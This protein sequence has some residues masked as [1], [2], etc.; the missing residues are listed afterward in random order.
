[1]SSSPCRCLLVSDF[2]VANLAGYLRS[3]PDSPAVETLEAPFGQVMPTL[4]DP[5]AEVWRQAYDAVV[6]WTQAEGVLDSFRR[7]LKYDPP[8]TDEL[9]GELDRYAEA[10]L[11]L[12]DRVACV[13]VP[14]W[15]APP[16]Q[17]G[18]GILDFREGGVSHTLAKL[19]ARLVD[20]LDGRGNIFVLNTQQWIGATGIA[21][22]SPKLWYM[23]KI[24]FGAEVFKQAALDVKAA[25]RAVRG[26]ARKLL[27]LDLDDT[28]WGGVVGEVGWQGLR[29]GGHDPLGEAFVD[30]QRALKAL[31]RRGTVLAIASKNEEAVALEAL[32]QHPEMVLRPDDFVAWRINWGDKA[33]NIAAIAEELNLGLEAVVFVDDNPAERARVREALPDVYVPEWPADKMLYPQALLSLRCFD[34][35]ALSGEDQRRTEMYA[36]EARRHRSQQAIGSLDEW[37]NSIKLTVTIEEPNAANLPRVAQLLNKTNQMN[38]STRRMTAH[39]LEAWL[40]DGARRMWCFRVADKFG[41]SGLCGTISVERQGDCCRIVD[42]ILSCRVFGRG[43]ETQMVHTAVEYARASGA[44]Q[45]AAR[46][47]PTAKNK[48]CLDFWHRSGFDVGPD[49]HQFTW[50]TAAAYPAPSHIRLQR[51]GGASA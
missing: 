24:P 4:L 49:G 19:N 28:L 36:S 30:F 11:P 35:A 26:G 7:T 46:L 21:A 44:A 31:E 41:D 29:L 23:G 5:G 9:L 1:M 33:A 2:N 47:V 42:L 17:R 14:C 37:L 50:S 18:L 22:F 6:V 10:L 8:A 32:R 25:L 43:I 45:V 27:V 16:Y 48:P 39:E 12:A 40:Q 15:V 34:T 38:L 13:L 3:I 51:A 20:R